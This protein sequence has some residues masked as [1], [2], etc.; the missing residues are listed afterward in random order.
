MRLRRSAALLVLLAACA[1]AP[2][3]PEPEPPEEAPRRAPAQDGIASYYGQSFA[4]RRTASGERFDPRKLTAAHRELPFGTRVRV[5]NLANGRSV[6]VRI[7]D[8]G[9]YAGGRVVD[10]SWEAARELDMLRSGVARV[11]LEVLPD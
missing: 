7:N 8:R 4:G 5:T 11:R 9:P 6:T 10:L 3:A 2:V 1:R